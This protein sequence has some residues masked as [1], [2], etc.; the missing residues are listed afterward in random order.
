MNRESVAKTPT[1]PTPRSSAPPRV[2]ELAAQTIEYVRAA[3][4][5]ELDYSGDT[6]PLVDHYLSTV[7]LEQGAIVE[8]VVS[9]GGAY[10]GEVVRQCL[11]GAWSTEADS[12]T[13]WRLT[14]PS[15]ISL[16]PAGMVA[17]AM[18]RSDDLD[19]LDTGLDASP[20]LRPHLEAALARMSHVTADEYYSLSGR[21]DTL[22]HLQ[23]V[24]AA[25][26]AMTS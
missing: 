6:L 13:E 2:S 14:L 25:S 7:P 22:E 15:G 8:L 17:S 10:F 9:T 4:G 3:V 5:I 20:I 26:L 19:D 1:P 16:A 21:L 11:G 24:L 18:A 12:P 23:V